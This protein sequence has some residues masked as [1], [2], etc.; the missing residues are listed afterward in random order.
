MY[1]P[2]EPTLAAVEE[3]R[4]ILCKEEELNDMRED[5]KKGRAY[6]TC[7]ESGPI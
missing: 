4:R 1:D 6:L 7:N 3:E 2:R 5:T